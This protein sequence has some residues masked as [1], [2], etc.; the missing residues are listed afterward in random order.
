MWCL[1][2]GLVHTSG[3]DL[4]IIIYLVHRKNYGSRMTVLTC[5]ASFSGYESVLQMDFLKENSLQKYIIS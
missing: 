3:G 5:S 4:C 2:Q 1:A